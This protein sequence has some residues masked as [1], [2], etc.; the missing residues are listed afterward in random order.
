MATIKIFE[1]KP[2]VFE[3]LKQNYELLKNYIIKNDG[4]YSL[5]VAMTGPLNDILII[6]DVPTIFIEKKIV[7]N[8]N[9]AVNGIVCRAARKIQW[10]SYTGI[11]PKKNFE[12]SGPNHYLFDY[13]ICFLE[14]NIEK[15]E[16]IKKIQLGSWLS[17]DEL[18]LLFE[19]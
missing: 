8:N 15:V 16:K 7:S 17:D 11:N 3:K 2:V 18:N 13:E 1:E 19:L 4:S 10:N 5:R 12:T 6:V 9:S 14:N